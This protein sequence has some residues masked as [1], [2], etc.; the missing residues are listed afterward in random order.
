MNCRSPAFL[1]IITIQTDVKV[2][3]RK[4]NMSFKYFD[5]LDSVSK[6]R[7]NDKL[8]LIGLAECPYKLPAGTWENNPCK[9]PSVEYGDIHNYLIETPGVY[10]RDSM[11]NYKSLEA[12]NYFKSG[13]VETVL[14]YKP[15]NSQ[16]TLLKAFVKPSQ[17]LNDEHYNP[18]VAVSNNGQISAAHCNCMA[19]LAES[20]SHIAA[21]LFKVEA[22]V[23][24]GYTKTACTDELCKWNQDFVKKV[25][26][27][28]I[29]KI[30][31]FTEKAINKAKHRN[32]KRKIIHQQATE[33]E[34]QN[35]LSSLKNLKNKPVVLS[36]FSGYSDDFHWSKKPK[37]DP[38]L[39]LPL[40][41]LYKEENLLL[42][43]A[44]LGQ[45]CENFLN[46]M[47]LTDEE[48]NFVNIT[49]AGQS[50]NMVWHE[51]RTGRIT[52]STVHAII[53][54][55]PNNPSKCAVDQ[56][57]NPR[58]TPLQT[59]AIKWG[60]EHE[61]SGLKSYRQVLNF[62]NQG[63]VNINMKNEGFQI[64]KERPYLGASADSIMSCDCHGKRIVEVKCP[65]SAKDKDLQAF[66]TNAD[67]YIQNNK[68]KRTHKYFSQVQL[69]MY[70]YNVE[71]CDFVVW[72][73]KFVFV[74][75][76]QRDDEFITEMLEKCDLMYLSCILPELLTR[77]QSHGNSKTYECEKD[78]EQPSKLYC[79][80]QK[81]EDDQKYVG[82]DNPDC[83]VQWFHLHCLKLKREPKGFWLC[84]RCKKKSQKKQLTLMQK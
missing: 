46:D 18:W 47:K 67:C 68:L 29:S 12:H 60:N 74:T 83:S 72:A 10:T 22:A 65:F 56:I 40:T 57:C 59:E 41:S 73:P 4:L 39:P 35:F 75:H 15:S 50:S 17:K 24:L 13:W 64:S 84:P 54:T 28:P 25:T 51:Q 36:C 79:L 34:K 77:K 70:V 62:S 32:K 52:S 81:P 38:K 71:V 45:K 7:Y 82:C 43:P 1:V 48:I 61:E 5:D 69:Q 42:Q 31:F 49:T 26:P 16:H 14:S 20:C 55:D 80:C 44:E 37:R 30:N 27:E 11:K 78:A 2:V 6:A 23:R 33:E 63:H 21:V 3:F 66:L 58:K 8:N 19:G 53:R 9:W 76:V